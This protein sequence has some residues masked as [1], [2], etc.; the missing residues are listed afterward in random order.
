M[1][2]YGAG[3]HRWAL[4]ERGR[5]ALDRR[6]TALSIG[7][8]CIDWNGTT[9]TIRLDEITFPIPSRLK[10]TIRIHP[11][12]LSDAIYMLDRA[13]RHRWSPHV[14]CAR[15]EVD[16]PRPGL[17]WLGR[18]YLDGN[19]GDRP[20]QEDFVRWDWSRASNAGGA[21]VLYDVTRRNDVATT[22]AL[23]FDPN[24][25]VV[26]AEPPP[27]CTLPQTRWRVARG[28]RADQ[29]RAAQVVRTLEDTPFYARSLLWTHLFGAATPAIHE[30]L[31]LDRFQSPWVQALLP[32]KNPRRAG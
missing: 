15:I 2:L 16:L 20:L 17:A 31:D 24:G 25:S 1:A 29:G 13:G 23:R 18:G 32:F 14:P 8:S 3:G 12:G 11:D 6:A 22:L 27:S 9:L 21:T 4:T 30:S 26:P 7:P 10:G 5:R 28:T 19:D